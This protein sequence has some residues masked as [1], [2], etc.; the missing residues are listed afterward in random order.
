[1]ESFFEIISPNSASDCTTEACT[2]IKCGT[3]VPR[4]LNKCNLMEGG[5]VYI[6]ECSD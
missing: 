6:C 4:K 3:G 2:N 5:Y 1:M